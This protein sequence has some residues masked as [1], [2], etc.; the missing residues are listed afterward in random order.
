MKVCEH[1]LDNYNGF[2]KERIVE[3]RN[4]HIAVYRVTGV[5]TVPYVNTTRFIYEQWPGMSP[6]VN[7]SWFIAKAYLANLYY[8]SKSDVNLIL[9]TCDDIID[10]YRHSR[11]NELFAEKTFP[12][13]LSTHWSNIYD[14]EIQQLLGF[15]SLCSYVLNKSSSRSVYLGVCPVQFALYVKLRT[16]IDHEFRANVWR[17][18]RIYS[19]DYNK[20]M[21][22]C[23]C[24]SNVKD[25]R[26]I[27]TKAFEVHHTKL[28]SIRYI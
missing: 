23:T 2:S 19:D 28:V 26:R 4:V 6:T 15:H 27:V 11:V 1:K 24:D 17:T 9:K 18:T 3:D 7:I 25:G 5:K 22:A 13:V 12:V 8:T 21:V 10:V 20:H 16:A 14:K